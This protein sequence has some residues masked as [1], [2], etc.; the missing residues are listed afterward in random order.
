MSDDPI[1]VEVEVVGDRD[2]PP[3]D[4]HAP[5]PGRA[6]PVRAERGSTHRPVRPSPAS[7]L[8]SW[9]LG[10]LFFIGIL[11][12]G[13]FALAGF[14]LLLVVRFI[15]SLFHSPSSHLSRR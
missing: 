2:S 5:T 13:L 12:F 10:I 7:S 9:F 6:E 4:R 3:P 11:L 1:E 15:L 8:L 14:I